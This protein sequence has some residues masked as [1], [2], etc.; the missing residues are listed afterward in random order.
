MKWSGGPSG[1]GGELRCEVVRGSGGPSGGGELRCEVVK[2]SQR[3]G[4]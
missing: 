3:V 2:G 4:S 1:G